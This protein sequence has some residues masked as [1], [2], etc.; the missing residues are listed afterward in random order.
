MESDILKPL[1]N[2]TA[3]LVIRVWAIHSVAVLGVVV[4]NL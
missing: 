3:G 4:F 1:V 2:R